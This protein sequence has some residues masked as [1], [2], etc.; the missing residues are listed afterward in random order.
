MTTLSEYRDY[1]TSFAHYTDGLTFA[2]SGPLPGCKNCGLPDDDDE[3][4][5]ICA[6]PFFS[7]CQCDFCGS[8]LGGNRV[9]AH[10]WCGGEI[11]HFTICEDCVYFL[12]Y[13]RLDDS[14]MLELEQE[15][16]MTAE[17]I[18]KIARQILGAQS[19]RRIVTASKDRS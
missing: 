8:R 4:R 12:E 19:A 13:G 5:D 11:C 10:A 6:E 9:H 15:S 17:A 18:D 3:A 2:S 7:W 16:G 1:V 14:R